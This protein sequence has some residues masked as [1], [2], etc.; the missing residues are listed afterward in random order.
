LKQE[1]FG[2]KKAITI[3]L[4]TLCH[5]FETLTM[6]EKEFVQEFLSMSRIISQMKTYSEKVSN[7]TIVNE[8]LNSLIKNLKKQLLQ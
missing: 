8:V 6:K 2:N 7:E 5:E 4:Q 3:K 1:F